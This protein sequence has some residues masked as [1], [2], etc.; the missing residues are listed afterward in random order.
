M[1][2]LSQTKVLSAS[3]LSPPRGMILGTSFSEQP[4]PTDQGKSGYKG[5]AI[6]V[7]PA[8]GFLMGLGWAAISFASKNHNGAN[9]IQ[10]T[11]EGSGSH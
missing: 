5:L 8:P 7:A 9:T 3:P 6:R 4:S 11:E 2:M 10:A 1:G